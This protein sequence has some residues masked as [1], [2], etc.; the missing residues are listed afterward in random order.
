LFLAS[1]ALLAGCGRGSESE[2]GKTG[3]AQPVEVGAVSVTQ[4]GSFPHGL[5]DSSFEQLARESLSGLLAPTAHPPS[6]KLIVQGAV[7]RLDEGVQVA[8]SAGL[9]LVGLP[10]R[11]E[12]HVVGRGPAKGNDEALKVATAA[13]VDLRA[14]MARHLALVEALPDRLV[15]GLDAAEAD[16]QILCARLLGLRQERMAMG[17]VG[18]LLGDPREAVADAAAGALVDMGDQAAVPVLI[19]SIKRGDLRSEVRAIE[20]MAGLGGPEA[21]AY[22]EMTAKGHPHP[23]VQNLSQFWLSRMNR[24]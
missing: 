5:D 4:G 13:L 11:L 18:R 17:A 16:E 7:L 12:V 3:R 24:R 23:E 14:A 2:V 8:L 20:A 6:G 10:F 19:A 15:R 9:R 1:I 21:Q 22:L